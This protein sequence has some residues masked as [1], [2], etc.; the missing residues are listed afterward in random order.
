MI[1]NLFYAKAI[2]QG[3]RLAADNGAM[4]RE[5]ALWKKSTTRFH[6]ALNP[7][8]PGLQ[9]YKIRAFPR[10]ERLSHPFETGCMMWL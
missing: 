7:P 2:R 9:Y 6:L 5:L 1:L 8:L 3:E 4:A 10:H